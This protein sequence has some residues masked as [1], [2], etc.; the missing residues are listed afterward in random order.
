MR[1]KVTFG[2]VRMTYQLGV[3]EGRGLLEREQHAAHG[4][5]E[6]GGEARGRAHADEVAAVRVVVEEREERELVL[7]RLLPAGLVAT[8]QSGTC[9]KQRSRNSRKRERERERERE[10][11][12]ERQMTNR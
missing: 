9:P 7:D 4:R 12:T 3:P 11:Q 5:A 1:I 6:R 2:W 8:C 10:S